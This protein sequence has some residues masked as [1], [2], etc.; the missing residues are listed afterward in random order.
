MKTTSKLLVIVMCA[1]MAFA[2][3]CGGKKAKKPE[4]VPYNIAKAVYGGDKDLFLANVAVE[5]EELAGAMF[6]G[7]AAMAEFQKKFEKEYGEGKADA[8]NGGSMPSPEEL[9]GKIKIE[10]KEGKTFAVMPDDEKVLVMEKDG[11]W[12]ADMSELKV[13]EGEKK[14]AMEMAGKMKTAAEN[15]TKKIGDPKYKDNPEKIIS[16]MMGEIMGFSMEQMAQEMGEAMKN[17]LEEGMKPT[18]EDAE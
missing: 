10:E 9:K 16:E 12:V 2:A 17:A 15:A 18:P 3:G 4:E 7:M 5:D 6:D 11:Y 1:A 14:K 13:P 8:M